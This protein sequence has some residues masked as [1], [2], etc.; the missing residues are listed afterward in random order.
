MAVTYRME[1]KIIIRSQIH[2]V[3]MVQTILSKCE[4]VLKPEAGMD[5]DGCYR[6]LILE[7]TEYEQSE[8]KGI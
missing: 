3:N 6:A 7:M 5:H 2:L 1:R 4:M 8:K